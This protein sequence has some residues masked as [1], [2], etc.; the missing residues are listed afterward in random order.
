MKFTDFFKGLFVPTAEQNTASKEKLSEI[1]YKSVTD[2]TW[3]TIIY[4]KANQLVWMS[5]N[6][7]YTNYIIWFDTS[8]K[9]LIIL[10]YNN[11]LQT[12][13]API[14]ITDANLKDADVNSFGQIYDIELQNGD[15]MSFILPISIGNINTITDRKQFTI[16]QEQEVET[17]KIFFKNYFV[18]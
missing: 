9:S 18:K 3:L 5:H 6:N 11:K 16:E 15:S 1:F 12:A 14:Y 8:S 17:F 7:I 13:G 10:P 4:A 2:K